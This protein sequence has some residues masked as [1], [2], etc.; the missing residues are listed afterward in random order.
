VEQGLLSVFVLQKNEESLFVKIQVVSIC[1]GG[2]LPLF[3]CFRIENSII[4]SFSSL[5]N[6]VSSSKLTKIQKLEDPNPKKVF[7]AVRHMW[8][9]KGN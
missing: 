4:G 8:L 1:F 9:K 2:N 5:P 7:Q 3:L 6:L